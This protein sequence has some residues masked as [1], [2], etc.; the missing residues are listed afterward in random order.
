MSPPSLISRR[1]GEGLDVEMLSHL[2]VEARHL[3]LTAMERFLG[4]L[5]RLYVFKGTE[6][7]GKAA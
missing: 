1:Y 4:L 3:K 2:D 5:H 6:Q 7:A